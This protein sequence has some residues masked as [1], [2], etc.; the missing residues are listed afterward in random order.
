MCRYRAA[1]WGAAVSWS[2]G[3]LPV[4]PM[5]RG[6]VTVGGST[7]LAFCEGARP[8]NEPTSGPVFRAGLMP[9][10]GGG[11]GDGPQVTP[12]AFRATAPAEVRSPSLL[13]ATESAPPD[14][15]SVTAC[16]GIHCNTVR[17]CASWTFFL[18]ILFIYLLIPEGHRERQRLRQREKQAPCRE[19][20]AGLDPGTP[21][22]G[23][24]P[25]AEPS[26]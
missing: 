15:G 2:R 4:A 10:V 11:G 24:E 7:G 19:P 6:Q 8:A 25:K 17:T 12:S 22:S 1:R 14:A 18:K 13:N 26:R 5:S 23:P 20:D 9:T 3:P 16:T 21:G